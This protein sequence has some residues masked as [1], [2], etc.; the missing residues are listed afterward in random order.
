[1]PPPIPSP[2]AINE[3]RAQIRSTYI[4]YCTT[5][6]KRT[7]AMAYESCAYALCLLR[8]V[9]PTDVAD[10]GSGYT[11]YLLRLYAAEAEHVVNVISVDDD[12]TWLARTG[13]FLERQ[14]LPSDGLLMWDEYMALDSVHDFAIYDFSGGEKREMGMTLVAER[15]KRNG[16]VLFD[17]AQHDGHRA[18]MFATGL[19]IFDSKP[20][21][22]D[23]VQRYALLGM[24]P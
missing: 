3:A 14:G 13:E 21:T 24:K 11:S 12:A 17:D 1:M 8:M 4:D 18:S 9:K 20:Y 7:M 19:T 16:M 10:F 6:S 22:I 23:V 15:T 2:S 5:V